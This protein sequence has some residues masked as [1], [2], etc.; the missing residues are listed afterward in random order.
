[1]ISAAPV[2]GVLVGALALLVGYLVGSVPAA[3]RIGRLAG[4]EPAAGGVPW[5]RPAA[6]WR[7]AGPGWGF[8]ALTA[9][10]AK[11]VV[12]VAI[13]VVTFS[14]AVG[15]A[16][17]VGAVLGAGWPAFGGGQ[18]DRRLATFAGAAFA[19]APP[20]GMLSGILGLAVLGVGRLAGRDA[21]AAAI[22]TGIASY[23]VLTLLLAPDLTRP[24]A[25]VALTL[26]AVVRLVTI[27]GR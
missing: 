19:L 22:A 18:G 20:A 14:W 9:D 13:G 12:P 5:G 10:L 24:A 23:L 17:G 6:V 26:V 21:R 2:A 8:L 1:M 15:W 27:R 3:A 16:A 11:G 7:S 25:L 4:I